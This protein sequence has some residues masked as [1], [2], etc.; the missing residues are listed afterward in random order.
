MAKIAAQMGESATSIT[1]SNTS[2]VAL[3]ANTPVNPTASGYAIASYSSVTPSSTGTSVSTN[4]VVKFGGN[5]VILDAM[6][7]PA[8]SLAPSNS[9]PPSISTGN[10]YLATDYGYAIAAY[11]SVTPSNSSPA[12]LSPALMYKPSALGFAISS[13]TSVTPS[14]TQTAVSSGDIV[15][16]GGSGV[17]VDSVPTPTSITPSNSSPV[18]LTA[19]TP[20]KP[21]ASGYAISSY[22]Y[23]TPST[24]NRSYSSLLVNTI[25]SIQ[26]RTGYLYGA[27][28][29]GRNL[30]SATAT[31]NYGTTWTKYTLTD[32]AYDS[33][34]ESATVILDPEFGTIQSDGTIKITRAISTAYIAGQAFLG[35]TTSGTNVYAGLRVLKNGTAIS[36]TEIYGSS[37][38]SSPS[39]RRI[40]TSFAVGD[41]ITIQSKSSSSTAATVRFTVNITTA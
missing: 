15:K 35:R 37:S 10:T 3:A 1:P 16:I 14:S 5:G 12:A 23:K 26:A 20:V 11:D 39:F 18:A 27:I 32:T 38:T 29:T 13:Y 41:I 4:D 33:S 25:N 34:G 9:N 7:A 36:G 19:N 21:T 22:S 40:S 30:F 2:P 8:T 28:P 24:A 17:I 31:C 6:P